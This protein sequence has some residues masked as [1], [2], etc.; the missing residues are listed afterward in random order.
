VLAFVGDAVHTLLVR[1]NLASQDLKTS[2]LHKQASALVCAKNQAKLFDEILEN[3]TEIE[4]ELATRAR[5]SSHN[6]VPKNASV[7]DYHKATALEAVIGYNYL[8]N[9]IE[10][11]REIIKC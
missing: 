10:R 11:V 3:L 4:K 6:T 5:N 2:V 8:K 9:N 1:E 7:G